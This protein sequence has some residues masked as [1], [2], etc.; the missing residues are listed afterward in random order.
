VVPQRPRTVQDHLMT[1][2]DTSRRVMC[3]WFRGRLPNKEHTKG[4]CCLVCEGK[5]GWAV[6]YSPVH[7]LRVREELSVKK[8]ENG[9]DGQGS[10]NFCDERVQ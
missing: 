1:T 4:N 6:Q 9:W 7:G 8:R 2:D 3:I 5:V 10:F